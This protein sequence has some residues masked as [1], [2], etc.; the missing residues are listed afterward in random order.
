MAF[1]QRRTRD[2][3]AAKA[4]LL[5]ESGLTDFQIA[6]ELGIIKDIPSPKGNLSCPRVWAACP[7]D[8]WGQIGLCSRNGPD[9]ADRY[10]RRELRRVKEL[11]GFELM[12]ICRNSPT[13]PFKALL[14]ESEIQ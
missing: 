12:E 7:C 11:I 1:H 4:Y 2:E 3:R 13:S 10:Y 5:R 14:P 9:Y 6:I 8:S